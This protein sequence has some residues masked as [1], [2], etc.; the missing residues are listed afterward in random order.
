VYN[1]CM[2]PYASRTSLMSLAFLNPNDPNKTGFT[3]GQAPALG[4]ATTPA[5]QSTPTPQQQPQQGAFGAQQP[6]QG[7]FGASST[8]FGG[9]GAANTGS[10]FGGSAFG[11]AP[12]SGSPFGTPQQPMGTPTQ[13]SGTVSP[14]GT[15]QQTAAPTSAP[16]PGF[17]AFTSAA[18]QATRPGLFGVAQSSAPSAF[19]GGSPSA[20]GGGTASA[21]GTISINCF[22]AL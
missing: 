4:A 10:A 22:N 7:T 2:L 1:M 21:F 11:Q 17:G 3:F 12:R 5:N 16:S 6:Q 19:G 9:F 8:P 14:F 13:A 20:F 15:T 18:T